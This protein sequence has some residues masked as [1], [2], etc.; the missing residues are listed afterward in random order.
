VLVAKCP[1]LH[2][3]FSTAIVEAGQLTHK[4]LM[5]LNIKNLEGMPFEMA[6]GVF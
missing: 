4:A 1:P 5:K 2:Q 3:Y 6:N